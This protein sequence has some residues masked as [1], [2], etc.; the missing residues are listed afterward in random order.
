ML[1]LINI[2]LRDGHPHRNPHVGVGSPEVAR[3]VY[4]VMPLTERYLFLGKLGVPDFGMMCFMLV[5]ARTTTASTQRMRT[6]TPDT[7][8]STFKSFGLE[9][10]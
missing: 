6:R 3:C 1:A 7:K 8:P 10:I 5:K 4:A 2:S 9:I